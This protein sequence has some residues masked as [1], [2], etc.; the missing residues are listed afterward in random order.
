MTTSRFALPDTAHPVMQD[1]LAYWQAA[2]PGPGLLPGRQHIDP[3]GMRHLLPHVWLMEVH[4]PEDGSGP[5]AGIPRL[6]FRLVG[7][8]VDLG[9]GDAKT[10]RWLHE[11]EPAFNTDRA[12]QA[13][14]IACIRDG[15]PNHRR[16]PPR[17]RFNRNARELERMILPLAEDGRQVDMLL[18]FTVFYDDH[19][20]MLQAML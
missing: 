17:F 8:H 9:F 1:G 15:T 3:A 4:P 11:I 14:Y 6:R 2:A 19:G 13:A 5:D 16:G 7:T 18:G 12:M 20:G 10:G